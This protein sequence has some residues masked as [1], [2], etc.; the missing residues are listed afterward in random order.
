MAAAAATSQCSCGLA[1]AGHD[2]LSSA[3]EL[4]QRPHSPPFPSLT[5]PEMIILSSLFSTLRCKSSNRNERK[6]TEHCTETTSTRACANSV[7][8]PLP[9]IIFPSPFTQNR[10]IRPLHIIP[11]CETG[12]LSSTAAGRKRLPRAYIEMYT[13][14]SRLHGHSHRAELSQKHFALDASPRSV[15][16]LPSQ[17]SSRWYS[18]MMI[19]MRTWQLYEQLSVPSTHKSAFITYSHTSV[20]LGNAGFRP[21]LVFLS[22]HLRRT[23]WDAKYN[24]L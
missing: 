4:D 3:Q 8:S 13:L 14:N 18:V 17:P 22:P 10:R 5:I 2:A 23:W 24:P 11:P 15:L 1:V 7:V 9:S 20:T 6:T 21:S 16:D 19:P 12:I